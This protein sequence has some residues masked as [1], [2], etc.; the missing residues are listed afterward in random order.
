MVKADTI[1]ELVEKLGLPKETAIAT[2]ER[3][4]GF[5]EKGVDEDFYKRKELLLPIKT[6]PFYGIKCCLLYT[7]RCV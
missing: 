3:Y 1:E 4:N 2:I 7:S 5:C 6:G